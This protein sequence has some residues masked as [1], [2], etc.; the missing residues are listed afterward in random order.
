MGNGRYDAIVVGGGH[1]GLICGAYLARAGLDVAIVER[2]DRVGGAAVTE[3]VWP[4]FKVSVL[5]YVV[6]L[7]QD[8]IVRT[9]DLARFGYHVYGLDPGSFHPFP[10]GGYILDWNDGARRRAELERFSRADAAAY[11]AYDAELGEMVS[12]VRPLLAMTPPRLPLGG[13]DTARA[14]RF[15]SHMLRHRDRLA[16]FID[17]M[18]LSAEDYLGR[19]FG[20]PHVKGSLAFGAVVGAYAGPMTP[21]TAYVL[22]HHRMGEVEGKRAEWGFVR[23]GMG[24]LSEALAAAARAAGAEVRTGSGVARID[25]AGGRVHGVT[26]HDGTELR[27]SVVAASAHPK[28][29]LLELVGREHLPGELVTD[30]QRFRSRSAVAKVNFALDALPNFS[31]LP[32]REPGPQ[33][34]EFIIGPTI[35]YIEKAWDE[36]K[37]GALCS[38]PVIDAVIP[39]TKDPTLAPEGKHIMTCFTQYVPYAPHGSSWQ[40]QRDVLAD[41]V[42]ATIESYAPGFSSSV[43]HRQVVTPQ[44]MEDTYGL[45]GGNIFHGE[46]SLDQ[47]FT[48]RPSPL[49]ADYRTPVHGLYLCGSGS[50]PGGGVMG[51]PG[52]NGAR[53]VL[54]DLRAER[55]RERLRRPRHP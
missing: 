3:E 51:A 13:R 41:R 40:E 19:H 1:N 52:R 34:P 30:I 42:M 11:E 28:L 43:L 12:V 25:V 38:E 4:G 53:A 6:S 9:L 29:V 45:L 7:L 49:V 2:R 32:G 37:F 16:R 35:D 48:G 44:D 18:T 47:L 21:G 23:G 27:A 20:H 55:V 33:H 8:D 14:L 36:A 10:D 39:T 31:A 22:L 46:L 15:G 24:A 5:S 26:L 17:L 54:A 50:H